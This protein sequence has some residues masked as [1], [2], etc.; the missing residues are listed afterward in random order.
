[1]IEA[2]Y[3][4]IKAVD[5]V[6]LDDPKYGGDWV[7]GAD[8]S[9]AFALAIAD[10]TLGAANGRKRKLIFPDAEIFLKQPV[11]VPPSVGFGL[12]GGGMTSTR[13]IVDPLVPFGN[14]ISIDSSQQ[15]VLEGFSLIA[16]QSNPAGDM[17]RF[18]YI[19]S[20]GSASWGHQLRD[21]LISSDDAGGAFRNGIVFSNA[22]GNN[23]EI[24]YWN[25][26][27]RHWLEAAFWLTGAQQKAHIFNNCQGMGAWDA[28]AFGQGGGKWGVRC[29]NGNYIWKGG[30]MSQCSVAAFTQGAQNDPISIQDVNS[31]L[32]YRFFDGGETPTASRHSIT[33]ARNRISSG[34]V[35]DPLGPIKY[36]GVG[37]LKVE[38]NDFYDAGPVRPAVYVACAEAPMGVEFDGNNMHTPGSSAISP[39]RVNNENVSKYRAGVR[40]GRRNTYTGTNGQLSWRNEVLGQKSDY[41]FGIEQD[42]HEVWAL[43]FS[44]FKANACCETIEWKSDLPKGINYLDLFLSVANYWIHGGGATASLSIGTTHG[45][46]E[47]IANAPLTVVG[48]GIARGKGDAYVGA[49]RT[50]A[51]GHMPSYSATSKLYATLTVSQ[52]TI[53][54]GVTSNFTRGF[55]MAPVRYVVAGRYLT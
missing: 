29:D 43:D 12:E 10:T 20:N 4:I 42:G 40:I 15:G 7:D 2:P 35:A 49:R 50:D 18:D 25:V 16:R 55:V 52:G 3:V 9:Q 34:P 5:K 28:L 22:F 14:G 54:D 13:L 53:G 11:S 44:Q 47:L 24:G 36:S 30:G 41:M 39:V 51:G 21:V 8:N 26:N 48:D 32:C 46:S 23:S 17:L 1:M 33:I 38:G 31:E 37:P 6:Y 45:G 19:S 27:V